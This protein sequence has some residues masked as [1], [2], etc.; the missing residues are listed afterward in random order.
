MFRS[1]DSSDAPHGKVTG[2][3]CSTVGNRAKYSS[4]W[5]STYVGSWTPKKF[6]SFSAHGSTFG[7]ATRYRYSDEV[8][9]LFAPMMKKLGVMC[10]RTMSRQPY[11]QKLCQSAAVRS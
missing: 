2:P 5:A 3:P 7:C 6:G 8:P 11:A 4:M 1:P 9:H 10:V